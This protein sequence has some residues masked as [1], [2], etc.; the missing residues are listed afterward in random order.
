M[1]RLAERSGHNCCRWAYVQGCISRV[2]VA[3]EGH[4]CWPR[5][6]ARWSGVE[7]LLEGLARASGLGGS[8]PKGSAGMGCMVLA[9][10]MESDRNGTASTRPTKC[11]KS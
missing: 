3:L 2:G 7:I 8:G 6:A 1:L 11:K 4:L 9:G 10:L 5:K